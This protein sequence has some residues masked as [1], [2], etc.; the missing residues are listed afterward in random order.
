MS[1]LIIVIAVGIL[2][3]FLSIY[4]IRRH[5]N[6]LAIVSEI[7]TSI[8]LVYLLNVLPF[9]IK[10]D[11]WK[12]LILTL[13]EYFS[14]KIFLIIFF[15]IAKRISFYIIRRYYSKKNKKD[16]E[17]KIQKLAKKMY[18]VKY[19]PKQ[20]LGNPKMANKVYTKTNVRFD[21]KGFPK[22]KSY[23]TVELKRKNFRKS[24]EQHF[25]MANRILYKNSKGYWLKKNFR[26]SEI[27]LL[28]KGETPNSF[29]WHHHQ[30]SGVMQ[31][32]KSDIHAKTPHIGGYS[33][34]GGKQ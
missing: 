22:F 20:K 33:I 34:W 13:L 8:A 32:V 2:Q 19:W 29:T 10:L 30:D 12:Y 21:K 3:V 25:Y 18:G 31:L 5:K 24:R 1:E 16:K 28:S 11:F 17:S 14:I 27:E 15:F 4:L 9:T 23:Y 6:K 26:N 7:I